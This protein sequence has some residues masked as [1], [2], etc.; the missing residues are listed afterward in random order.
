MKK[1]VIAI[2][3]V[4]LA[5]AVGLFLWQTKVSAPNTPKEEVKQ[6]KETGPVRS[7]LTGLETTVDK[8]KRPI[9]AVMVENSPEARPQSGLK[10]AGVVFEAVAEGGIT[11]F[12]ALYQEAQ[13]DLIGP[14]RSIRPYFV[15]W[16]AGFDAGLAHVGGSE[17]AL[18][19]VKSGDYVADLDRSSSSR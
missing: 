8:A 7:E 3:I 10:D 1:K 13:P 19:M 6:E 9:T 18:N 2:I 15:E 17:L 12:V 14:V 16:A 11:R 5:G 4:L